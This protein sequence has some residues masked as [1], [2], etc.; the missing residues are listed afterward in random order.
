MGFAEV[1]AELF[2]NL[3]SLSKHGSPGS[4][5]PR[6]RK[7]I[8]MSSCIVCSTSWTVTDVSRVDRSLECVDSLGGLP[9]AITWEGPQ[10]CLFF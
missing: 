9:I 2:F 7:G 10:K 6:P 4:L 5:N 3:A 1:A 8:F